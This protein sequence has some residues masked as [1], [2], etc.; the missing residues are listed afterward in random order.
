MD[1]L[2]AGFEVW[3]P[4]GEEGGSL[5]GGDGDD[6]SV[7]GGVSAGFK[8]QGPAGFIRRQG[9]DV[10]VLAY[11]QAVSQMAGDGGYG[12]DAGVAELAALVPKRAD[13][14]DGGL[15]IRVADGED[16]AAVVEYPV[17][18]AACGQAATGVA[19]LVED[20]DGEAGGGEGAGGGKAGHAGADD[21]NGVYGSHWGGIGGIFGKPQGGVG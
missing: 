12:G 6:E 21:R 20:G 1:T 8:V 18:D 11:V 10:S 5:G 4:A 19:A 2:Q 13:W 17:V 7:E 14:A 3:V 9:F 15:E 16:L